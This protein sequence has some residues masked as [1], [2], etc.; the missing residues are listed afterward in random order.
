M[1]VRRLTSHVAR[2]GACNVATLAYAR[3][4]CVSECARQIDRHGEVGVF[5]E[6]GADG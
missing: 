2:L 4:M 6:V 3:L 1:A 5:R